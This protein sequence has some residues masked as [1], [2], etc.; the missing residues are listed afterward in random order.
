MVWNLQANAYY[1][2]GRV[3]VPSLMDSYLACQW[4]FN[5]GVFTEVPRTFSVSLLCMAMVLRQTCLFGT[6]VKAYQRMSFNFR[7][8]PRMLKGGLDIESTTVEI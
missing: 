7:T 6:G 3:V 2:A 8:R 5:N 1:C 4:M